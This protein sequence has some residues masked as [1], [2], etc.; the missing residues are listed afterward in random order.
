[1]YDSGGVSQQHWFKII[2]DLPYVFI[3]DL[4]VLPLQ[5]A[6]KHL[7]APFLFNLLPC[8]TLPPVGTHAEAIQMLIVMLPMPDSSNASDRAF[9]MAAIRF[10]S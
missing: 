4:Y 3:L 9:E 7:R 10:C 1:M 5:P 6:D 2:V 8:W